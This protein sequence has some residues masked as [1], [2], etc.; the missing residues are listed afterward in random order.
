MTRTQTTHGVTDRG[1]SC[2]SGVFFR[3]NSPYFRNYKRR[4]QASLEY[5]SQVESSWT[6][7]RMAG[8]RHNCASNVVVIFARENIKNN[9][10]LKKKV[11][12]I[13]HLGKPTIVVV[14]YYW[15][16]TTR[17]FRFSPKRQEAKPR[18]WI[19]PSARTISEEGQLRA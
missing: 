7:I 12:D 1:R 6:G 5:L 10:E 9:A 16:N 17:M 19:S 8:G 11:T 3:Y 13:G 15:T 2:R 4:L 14:T 18:M